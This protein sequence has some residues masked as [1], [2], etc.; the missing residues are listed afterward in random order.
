MRKRERGRIEKQEPITLERAP[1]GG[2][3]ITGICQKGDVDEIC[4]SLLQLSMDCQ[5]SA[6][7]V[8]EKLRDR[9]DVEACRSSKAEASDE[10]TLYVRIDRIR[11]HLRRFLR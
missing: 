11:K 1:D 8:H 2:V 7:G 5:D 10:N 4:D 9:E 3:V 6:F